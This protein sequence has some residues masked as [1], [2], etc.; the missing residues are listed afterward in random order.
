MERSTDCVWEYEMPREKD[1]SKK[2]MLLNTTNNA[3]PAPTT[4]VF[5]SMCNA[6]TR[7]L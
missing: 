4:S 1:T 3:M 6:R 5:H 2:T 7:L